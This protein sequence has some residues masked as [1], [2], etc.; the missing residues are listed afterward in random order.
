M[1]DPFEFKVYTCNRAER[2]PVDGLLLFQQT[3]LLSSLLLE[4]RGRWIIVT[5]DHFKGAVVTW[6]SILNSTPQMQ[7]WWIKTRLI[8]NFEMQLTTNPVVTQWRGG[9]ATGQNNVNSTTQFVELG[10]MDSV[11]MN[12]NKFYFSFSLFSSPK[13]PGRLMIKR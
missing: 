1:D 9:I 6:G 10:R 11:Q 12:F 13:E 5:S 2:I 8:A 3:W 7:N 4:N